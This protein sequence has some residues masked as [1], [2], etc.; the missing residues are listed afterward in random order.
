[1]PIAQTPRVINASGKVGQY[2]V[3][4]SN[5]FGTKP[6]TISPNPLSIQREINTAAQAIKSVFSFLR[7]P[8][9]TKRISDAAARI[10]ESHI[11]GTSFPCPSSPI[12]RY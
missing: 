4:L 7:V 10:T 8:G 1:M 9:L 3:T 11:K 5:G 6:P 12:K 2:S